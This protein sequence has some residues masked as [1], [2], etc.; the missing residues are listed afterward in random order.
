MDWLLEGLVQFLTSPLWKYHI[1]DFV[2]QNCLIFDAGEE[3]KFTY[4]DVH[5]EYKAIVEKL[6]QNF[7]LQELHMTFSELMSACSDGFAKNKRFKELFKPLMAVEDFLLFKSIMVQRNIRLNEEAEKAFEKQQQAAKH[8]KYQLLS[9][10]REKNEN[11]KEKPTGATSEDT[12]YDDEELARIL[13]ESKIEY[14][15][16]VSQEEEEFARLLRQATEE[17]LKY[18]ETEMKT[19]HYLNLPTA[20]VKATPLEDSVLP[21]PG[22]SQSPDIGSTTHEDIDPPH[23][24][25]RAEIEQD[26]VPPESTEESKATIPSVQNT[27]TAGSQSKATNSSVQGTTTT[28]PHEE[29]SSITS[30]KPAIGV[31]INASES[32]DS[33]SQDS[34]LLWLESAKAETAISHE[35]TQVS[36]TVTRSSDLKTREDYLKA[37]RDSIIA[38]KKKERESEL[39]D[40]LKAN[41]KYTASEGVDTSSLETLEEASDEPS[42]PVELEYKKNNKGWRN[43]LSRKKPVLT[44]DVADKIK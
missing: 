21:A 42:K 14:E 3:N 20:H 19:Q 13:I 16:Q 44:P 5:H 8:N 39:Q 36:H 34:A 11:M 40:Y 38:K 31:H 24:P 26:T 33:T 7:F 41:P 25:M 18:Y 35:S 23:S 4:T 43:K 12:Q 30:T 22:D 32:K 37:K 2:D 27:T 15:R 17:S 10:K 6:L 28:G 29:E 1:E 9:K